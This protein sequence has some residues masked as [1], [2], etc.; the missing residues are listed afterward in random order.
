MPTKNSTRRWLLAACATA[1]LVALSALMFRSDAPSSMKVVSKPLPPMPFVAAQAPA[2]ATPPPP[3]PQVS[4][5]ENYIV[6]AES[7]EAAR[8]AVT[9]AGGVVTGGLSI[10]RAGGAAL[11]GREP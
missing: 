6:Q 2:R 7:V 4:V 3:I 10:I 11:G 8:S 5:R 1:V 9:R